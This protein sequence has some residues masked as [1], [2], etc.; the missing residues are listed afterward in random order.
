MFLHLS[1]GLLSKDPGQQPHS[2]C[3]CCQTDTFSPLSGA[4]LRLLGCLSKLPAPRTSLAAHPGPDQSGLC[5]MSQPSL[6]WPA[7]PRPLW[8]DKS[9]SS[10]S[11]DFTKAKGQ[12]CEQVL[13]REV[14][15]RMKWEILILKIENVLVHRWLSIRWKNRN[16]AL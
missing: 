8:G 1:A 2:L 7:P 5:A 14:W 11:T 15:L 16:S 13:S 6:M 9:T 4:S 10:L 3:P 12:L